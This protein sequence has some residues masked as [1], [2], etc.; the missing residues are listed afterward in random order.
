MTLSVDSKRERVSKIETIKRDRSLAIEER[1]FLW[2]RTSD[3]R[4]WGI[5]GVDN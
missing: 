5:A 2:F 3:A 1:T 4:S